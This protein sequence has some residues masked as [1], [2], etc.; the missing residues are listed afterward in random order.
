M[1]NYMGDSN[2]SSKAKD[3]V[4]HKRTFLDQAVS[5]VPGFG[6]HSEKEVLRRR[7]QIVRDVLYDE[8]GKV[9]SNFM[10]SHRTIFETYGRS[11][12]C[13]LLERIL[14]KNDSLMQKILHAER[15]YS[16]LM[17]TP[18]ID[19]NGISRLTDYDAAIEKDIL[20][21]NDDATSLKKLISSLDQL[22]IKLTDIDASIDKIKNDFDNRDNV[23]KMIGE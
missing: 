21:L 13:N 19:V 22:N 7:N 18:I 8:L 15:G 1:I 17:N 3:I 14:M 20:T 4:R 2:L 6:E 9:N 16:P 12:E 5:A 10:N 23:V 11:M